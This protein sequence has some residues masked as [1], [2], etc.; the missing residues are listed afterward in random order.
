MSKLSHLCGPFGPSVLTH[1]FNDEFFQG[2]FPQSEKKSATWSPRVNVRETDVA[3]LIEA[4]VPGLDPAEIEITLK[5]KTLTLKGE[6]TVA[7]KLEGERFH[8]SE[9]SR[10]SFTR[11]FNFPVTVDAESVSATSEHGLLTIEIKKIPETQPTR[12]EIKTTE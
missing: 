9:R 5:D 11:T 2:L 6:K 3:Y 8:V 10:G 7:T 1:A 4:E 12:I